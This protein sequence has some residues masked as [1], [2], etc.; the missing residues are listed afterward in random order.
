[1][2]GLNR[3]TSVQFPP[4]KYYRKPN[5][6]TP[7]QQRLHELQSDILKVDFFARSNLIFQIL[8]KKK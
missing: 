4:G 1:M 6:V 2:F 7:T 5:L 3:M 8:R